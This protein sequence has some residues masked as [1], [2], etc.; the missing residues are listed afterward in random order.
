MTQNMWRKWLRGRGEEEWDIVR[1][2]WCIAIIVRA[3][4][5]IEEEM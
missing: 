1:E 3:I 2:Y 5:I 4:N